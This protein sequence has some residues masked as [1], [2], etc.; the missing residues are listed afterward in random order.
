M[1][2]LMKKK[3]HLKPYKSIGNFSI[4]R[5]SIFWQN[6]TKESMNRSLFIIPS[7]LVLR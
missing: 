2:A 7:E 1:V 3:I 4:Q 5:A 6:D